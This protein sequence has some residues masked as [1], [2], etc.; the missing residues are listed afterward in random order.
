MMADHLSADDWVMSMGT[1][2]PQ[3]RIAATST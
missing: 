3:L 2:Q 1:S